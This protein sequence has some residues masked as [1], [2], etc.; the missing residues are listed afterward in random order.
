MQ[1]IPVPNQSDNYA[2]LLVDEETEEAAAIDIFD[3]PKVT[4]KAKEENVKITSLLTTHHH[5][6]HSGGNAAFAKQYPGIKIY[7]GSSR[8]PAMTDEVK[9]GDTLKVGANITIK[10]AE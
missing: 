7:G 2:Y 1:I 5:R 4:A 10:Y 6:D 3:V 8:C 9:D